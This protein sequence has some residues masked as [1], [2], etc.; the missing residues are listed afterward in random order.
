MEFSRCIL[1]I[2]FGS[3]SSCVSYFR[4]GV[5]ES[6]D[7]KGQSSKTFC[8]L[9]AINLK[10]DII[11]VGDQVEKVLEDEDYHIIRNLKRQLITQKNIFINGKEYTLQFLI[12]RIFLRLKYQVQI[13]L[14]Q[15]VNEAVLTVPA[16][17]SELTRHILKDAAALVDLKI[18][19]IINEPTAAA[20]YQS[21]LTKKEITCLFVDVGCLTVDFSIC[22]LT[23][24]V[25]DIVATKGDPL[26]G[27][28]LVDLA[29]KDR[30]LEQIKQKQPAKS[31]LFEE[32]NEMET[33]LLKLAEDLK[34]KFSDRRLEN[35]QFTQM[36]L[37]KS[38]NQP[39]YFTFNFSKKQLDLAYEP[40]LQRLT[41]VYNELFNKCP[42]SKSDIE[43]ILLIGG[44][45]NSNYYCEQIQRI[46]KKPINKNF[47]NICSVS[48]GAALH[49]AYVTGLVTSKILSDVVPLS[50]GIQVD[51]GIFEKMIHSNAKIPVF[52]SANFTTTEDFQTGVAIKIFEGERLLVKECNFLGEIF[53]D[54]IQFGLRGSPV[55]T[56]ILEYTK[57]GTI[58][59][60]AIDAKTKKEEFLTIKSN[61]RL[62]DQLISQI[63]LQAQK[64]YKS[65][66]HWASLMELNVKIRKI[67][68]NLQEQIKIVSKVELLKEYVYV[69]E[70][71]A[72]SLKYEYRNLLKLKDVLEL[73]ELFTNKVQLEINI[74][75]TIKKK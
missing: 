10:E 73:L 1:G 52:K 68:N 24:G 15:P 34:K 18:L 67:F 26:G 70:K 38:T 69:K 46:I 16:Y 53:L 6:I 59:A 29:I 2:D 64:Y 45:A 44:P 22:N 49:G 62:S 42:V 43:E 66:L 14:G 47:D 36:F 60:Y 32:G 39:F 3:Q 13:K 19:R 9:L 50:I 30:L 23:N 33:E 65:D 71:T 40:F 28:Y 74:K 57:D 35:T 58:N 21:S 51:N 17:F 12:S 41:K 4:N 37:I 61:T 54:K 8:S 25:I 11:V 48:L 55:I 5:L 27:H 72:E 63:K 31:I 75:N 56:V 20:I 7:V